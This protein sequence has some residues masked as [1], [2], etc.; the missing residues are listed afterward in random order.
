M[1]SKH[2][3]AIETHLLQ[4]D[5]LRAKAHCQG[6]AVQVLEDVAMIWESF[7][8]RKTMENYGDLICRFM[9]ISRDLWWFHRIYGDLMGY[10]WFVLGE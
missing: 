2:R 6:G 3:H 1:L 8:R 5:I 7:Q 10:W 4:H 9:V